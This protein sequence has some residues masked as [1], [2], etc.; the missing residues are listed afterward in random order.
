MADG[1]Y[2]TGQGEFDQIDD[3]AVRQ[4]PGNFISRSKFNP[5]THPL[6]YSM[7]MYT[8]ARPGALTTGGLGLYSKKPLRPYAALLAGAGSRFG[9]LG[10]GAAI[11]G[12]TGPD[13]FISFAARMSIASSFIGV[14]R[15]GQYGGL[16]RAVG[17][18]DEKAG[19]AVG[20]FG[21][22]ASVLFPQVPHEGIFTPE[23]AK[24]A[25]LYASSQT[26]PSG[27]ALTEDAVSAAIPRRVKTGQV[28]KL[29]K[30]TRSQRVIDKYTKM[31]G[32]R[33][34]YN[35]EDMVTKGRYKPQLPARV[36]K[37]SAKF[38]TVGGLGEL[39]ILPTI[40]EDSEAL[41][42]L[43]AKTPTKEIAGLVK[44][45]NKA[46]SQDWT[47]VMKNFK[48]TGEK[49]ASGFYQSLFKAAS[50]SAGTVTGVRV[51]QAGANRFMLPE[52]HI[53]QKPELFKQY[54]G[55][56]DLVRSQTGRG[57]E[58][59]RKMLTEGKYQAGLSK[60]MIG[61]FQ[62]SVVWDAYQ[63]MTKGG[64]IG[65]LVGEFRLMFKGGRDKMFNKISESVGKFAD[66]MTK[67]KGT[68]VDLVSQLGFGQAEAKKIASG[69]SRSRLAKVT[70]KA[71]TTIELMSPWNKKMAFQARMKL[72][73]AAYGKATSMIHSTAF[74]NYL[75][76]SMGFHY[77]GKAFS[78]L[79]GAAAT[80]VR[81]GAELTS[82]LTHLEFGSGKVT[83][84]A[85]ASTERTR[86]LQAIQY[87]GLNARSYL[88]RESQIY[89]Q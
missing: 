85:Q 56:F 74:S 77:I 87:S 40:G 42:R 22:G 80:G 84:T 39:E 20:K 15:G 1:Y 5:Y 18:V 68:K 73:G 23:A 31:K 64:P 6:A 53:L 63:R 44:D 2:N 36:Y 66:T 55:A 11:A 79:I 65:G 19:R 54:P 52:G 34:D 47:T 12:T 29:I 21:T 25:R 89:S 24:Y 76:L 75:L 88:G 37:Q 14:R 49:T 69:L 60:M 17:L 35:L 4:L 10:W 46:I 9:A 86:A 83:M 58:M 43:R 70:G 41:M 67:V 13:N 30:K 38:K 51:T 71:G 7:R 26:L 62:D 81:K 3:S 82:R 72:E 59:I 16:A 28:D 32:Y 57:P 45:Y 27:F 61:S 8:F 48:W 50:E 78:G 33:V